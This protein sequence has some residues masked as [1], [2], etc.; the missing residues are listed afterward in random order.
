MKRTIGVGIV[1]VKPGVSWSANGHIPAIRSLPQYQLRALST[2]RRESAEAAAEHFS[3]PQA[4]DDNAMLAGSP[5][6]DVVVVAVNV[7]SHFDAVI[8]AIDAGKTVYCE[9]PLAR[10]LEEAEEMARRAKQK[11]VRTVVGLQARSAPLVNYLRDLIA[12]GYIGDVLSTSMIAS[13]VNWGGAV[14][15]HH[16]YTID[17]ADGATL[18][19]IAVGHA[20]DTLCYCLGEFRDVAAIQAIRR[21][22]FKLLDADGMPTGVAQQYREAIWGAGHDVERKVADQ[23]AFN[24]TLESG[25][26]ASVHFR[27]GVCRGTNLLWEINGTVGDLRVTGWAGLVEMIDLELFGAQAEEETLQPLAVPSQYDLAP[28]G[29]ASGPAANLTQAYIRLASDIDTG[30]TSCPSFDD[31]VK[32]H[33]LLDAVSRSAASGMREII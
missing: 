11:G 14:D 33:R 16:T 32:T 25:A 23:V 20:V 4:F 9:W 17:P 21:P 2:T 7:P 3:V 5:D 28:A 10:N 27:G 26:V 12:Q 22:T 29:S 31:A 24:G 13:G 18:L 30:T 6:V 1:G 15:Q 8:K 19:S